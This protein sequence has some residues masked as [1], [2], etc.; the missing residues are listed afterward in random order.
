MEH[1]ACFWVVAG[2]ERGLGLVA[3]RPGDRGCRRCGQLVVC[4]T[5]AG[6]L[7]VAGSRG[8]PRGGLF[9]HG[10]CTALAGLL[11][12]WCVAFGG[13]GALWGGDCEGLCAGAGFGWSGGCCAGPG[14]GL[15][16]LRT[17]VFSAPGGQGAVLYLSARI[18]RD[19]AAIRPD[20]AGLAVSVFG[21]SADRLG[22]SVRMAARAAGL[23][24]AEGYTGHS[25]QGGD[26]RGSRQGRRE[27]AGAGPGRP[28]GKPG[29]ACPLRPRRAGWAGGC[30]SLLHCRARMT[31]MTVE[32]G[33]RR[34][35]YLISATQSRSG[36]TAVKRRP[37]RS[38]AAGASFAGVVVRYRFLARREIPS[39]PSSPIS[40]ATRLRPTRRS[41]SSASS[42]W[43]RGAPYVSSDPTNAVWDQRLQPCVLARAPRAPTFLPRVVARPSRRR[44]R[45]TAGRQGAARPP[46]RPA[47]ISS[48]PLALPGEENRC[49]A[50]DLLLLPK[51]RI[52]TTQPAQLLTLLLVSPSAFCS[53]T[54]A[55]C[56]Q[57]RSDS[58]ALP[59][60]VATS[61]NV[62]P[63]TR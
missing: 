56:A 11:H 52:L 45:C 16:G 47:G 35:T 44:A 28:L 29:D 15:R 54:S 4:G 6:F 60:S 43:I 59:S 61:R 5:Q 20:P 62:R 57:R 31:G 38:G 41:W 49:L 24:G 39:I 18:V 22:A 53:S 25:G 12:G 51:T 48:R 37:T 7:V 8:K 36:A 23:A 34:L 33:S 2:D 30:C 26:G 17:L 9:L 10:F 50:Q 46:L 14:R 32:R 42:A 40:L 3:S 27:S 21:L 55:C 63:L 58:A 19:L 13:P 1:L